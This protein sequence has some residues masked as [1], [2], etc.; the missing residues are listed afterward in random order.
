MDRKR[1][2]Q[3]DTKYVDTL[4]GDWC[5][6]VIYSITASIVTLPQSFTLDSYQTVE[7]NGTTT[8]NHFIPVYNGS[9][10]G[11]TASDKTF[12][13]DTG[14]TTTEYGWQSLIINGT[15][16]YLKVYNGNATTDCSTDLNGTTLTPTV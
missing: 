5:P 15:T 2:M 4:L 6:N 3:V 14:T 10:T 7:L 13:G 16:Y 11:K 9:T 8:K 12:F 1:H